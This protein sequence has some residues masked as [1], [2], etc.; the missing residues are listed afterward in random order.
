M[1]LPDLSP[2]AVDRRIGFALLRL[3]LG[4]N[5]LGRSIVRIP[6]LQNF[7]NGMAD[8][9]AET[10]LHEGFVFLYAYVIVIT[11]TIIGVMLILGWKTRWA[12]TVMGLLLAS[13]AFGVI[14]QQ[15]FGTAANIMIY[16]I[17]VYLL[18]SNTQFDHF[19][20]DRGF[21]LSAIEK[22]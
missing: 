12:L 5:M 16:G 2:S 8:N 19:G 6:E 22:K 18:L 21:L 14:L 1:T 3:M 20:I 4:I 11:E 9:F 17:G 10:F 13:L 15:N 7:A